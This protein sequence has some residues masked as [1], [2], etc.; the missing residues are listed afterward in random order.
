MFDVCMPRPPRPAGV[1][2]RM[3]FLHLLMAGGLCAPG[4]TAAA[5]LV[6]ASLEDAPWVEVRTKHFRILTDAGENAAMPVAQRLEQFGVLLHTLYPGLRTYPVLPVDVYVFRDQ[7]RADLFSPSSP[8][9]RTAFATS[10]PGRNL[11]VIHAQAEGAGN[12]AVIC[13]EYTHLFLAANFR[14]LPLC[15]DEGLAEYYGTF[16]PRGKV[17][18]FGHTHEGWVAWLNGHE[19]A[20][21]GLLFAGN[22]ASA[23]YRSNNDLERTTYAEGWA[24]THYLMAAPDREARLDSVLA[25][26]R[27]GRPAR[28]AF[29]DQ[30]PSEQWPQLVE[31]VKRYIH[32]GT[33]E[34][35]SVRMAD[36]LD[37]FPAT[38]RTVP[39]GEVFT[40]LGDLALSLG[41]DRLPDAAALYDAALA[42][43]STLARA[44]AG[45]GY[46]ADQRA[47]TTLAERCY[48]RAETDAP[49]DSRVALFA[50]LGTVQ[51]LA[52]PSRPG[53]I[54]SARRRLERCRSL[55][56][57][58]P[59]AVGVLAELDLVQGHVTEDTRR[60][61]ASALDQLPAR[62]DFARAMKQVREQLDDVSRPH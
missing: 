26:L 15:F 47:D 3:T 14:G 27:R 8:E 59:E 10:G 58:N 38:T 1:R 18:E 46:V 54:S 57:D 55:D 42:R 62:E 16:R 20:D 34:A 35:R 32:D 51:R 52:R 24:L 56:P 40:S 44:R 30:F 25:A 13:H 60:A 4:P 37:R 11:F 50:G 21:I 5:T 53:T 28:T 36:E 61:L 48:V 17:M 12:S 29:R 23:A 19:Y 33:L 31:T 9:N 2:R 6:P 41:P 49:S 43:D 7:A 22:T 45:S 39:A